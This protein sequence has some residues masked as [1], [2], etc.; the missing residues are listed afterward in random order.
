MTL[1]RLEERK[2]L[3]TVSGTFEGMPWTYSENMTT[4]VGTLNFTSKPGID[5]I[6]IQAQHSDLSPGDPGYVANSNPV[7]GV[8]WTNNDDQGGVNITPGTHVNIT[9]KENATD[10]QFIN[11]DKVA[12]TLSIT[13]RAVTTNPTPIP[14]RRRPATRASPRPAARSASPGGS[15]PTARPPA[16]GRSTSRT[17]PGGPTPSSPAARRSPSTRTPG[18]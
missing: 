18:T 4:H 5:R 6:Q 10:D 7:N 12:F 8:T 11:N 17:S 15:P 9:A 16:A 14:P 13:P 3:S 2:V 1:D